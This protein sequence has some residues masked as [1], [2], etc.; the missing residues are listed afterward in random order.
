MPEIKSR[1]A[2]P[3]PGVDYSEIHIPDE[4]EIGT[5]TF[6]TVLESGALSKINPIVSSIQNEPIFL[7]IVS[8]NI[9]IDQVTVMIGKSH[10]TSPLDRKVFNIPK[11]IDLKK[12]NDFTVSFSNWDIKDMKLNE[13]K[14]SPAEE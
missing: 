2:K 5:G 11:D 4:K 13:K 3:I 1:E 12:T 9:A 7:M 6:T 10:N 14:L 8:I